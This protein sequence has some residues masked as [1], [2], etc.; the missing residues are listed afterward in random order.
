MVSNTY[1]GNDN[2]NDYANTYANAYDSGTDAD[3]ATDGDT[4][5]E[6]DTTRQA[7]IQ[8]CTYPYSPKATTPR[9]TQPDGI[10]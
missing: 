7:F 1:G 8:A 5:T 4:F 10:P 6:H 3:T 2:A 9:I